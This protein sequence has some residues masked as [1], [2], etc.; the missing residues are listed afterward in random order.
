V[1]ADQLPGFVGACPVSLGVAGSVVAGGA[2]GSV[3][4]GVV[5][6][7]VAGA[8]AMSVGGGGVSAGGGMASSVVGAG[9]SSAGLLQPE[10]SAAAG[11][12]NA[13]SSAVRN[14]RPGAFKFSVFITSPHYF[15]GNGARSV[16]AFTLV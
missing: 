6:G 11:K 13:S 3:G 1:D 2:F 8:G 15:S 12:V 14:E 10:T 9:G 4:G 5:V 7:S 16:A